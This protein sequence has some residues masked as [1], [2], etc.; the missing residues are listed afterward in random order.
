M[1]NKNRVLS[2]ENIAEHVWSYDSDILINTVEVYIRYLRNKIDKPFKEEPSLIKT[3]RGFG[4]KLE[5]INV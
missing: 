1:R 5:E 4:Y 2:K 3:S